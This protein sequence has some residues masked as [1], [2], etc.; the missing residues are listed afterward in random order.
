ML[1]QWNKRVLTDWVH[2]P[3]FYKAF[4]RVSF[5]CNCLLLIFFFS[6]WSLSWKQWGHHRLL[7]VTWRGL[8]ERSFCM[9]FDYCEAVETA[10]EHD[11]LQECQVWVVARLPILSAIVLYLCYSLVYGG[12]CNS[13][14]GHWIS[15][16]LFLRCFSQKIAKIVSA[17]TVSAKI[18]LKLFW[19]EYLAGASSSNY[20]L[21]YKSNRKTSSCGWRPDTFFGMF[22]TSLDAKIRRLSKVKS[23]SSL[24]QHNNEEVCS[25]KLCQP[26]GS[27]DK[28]RQ[29]R[30]EHR[31][32]QQARSGAFWAGAFCPRGRCCQPAAQM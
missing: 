10:F 2:V 14:C 23:A 30:G 9:H 12:E 13:H 16:K 32:E 29:W 17:A 8:E 5:L 24:M 21:L 7:S 15:L 19:K 22:R 6:A 3:L 28:S 1:K 31:S 11:F 26:G 27:G 20:L 25:K 4:H 18:S